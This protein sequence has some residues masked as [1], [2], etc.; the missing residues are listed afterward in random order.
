MLTLSLAD[1]L[2]SQ[3]PTHRDVRWTAAGLGLDEAAFDAV[4]QR[5]LELET[6]GSIDVIDM[7]RGA[8]SMSHRL[9]AISFVKLL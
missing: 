3:L 4:A 6:T 8:Q 7:S 2:L 5:L 1:E 9:N